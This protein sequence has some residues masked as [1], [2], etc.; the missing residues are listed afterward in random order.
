[1]K[2]SLHLFNRH[3]KNLVTPLTKNDADNLEEKLRPSEKF[4]LASAKANPDMPFSWREFAHKYEHGTIRN[5]FSKLAHLR[6]LEL[7]CRSTDAYYILHTADLRRPRQAVTVTHTG[8]KYNVRRMKIDNYMEYLDSLGWEEIWKV[9]DVVLCFEVQGLYEQVTKEC[10][11]AANEQSK[12]IHF[13]SINWQT[14]RQLK[15]FLHRTGTVTCYLKCS[16]SP[17]E[18]TPEG[19]ADLSAVLGK[20]QTRLEDALYAASGITTGTVPCVSSWV[21]T[22]WHCGKD[23]KREISGKSFNITYKTW[24]GA[25]VRIYL[26]RHGRKFRPRKETIEQPRKV[27]PRAFSEKAVAE[28]DGAR[29]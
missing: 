25:L 29:G 11:L 6:L 17:V 3:Y 21:V 5:A 18:V 20:V 7:Q 2:F 1:M 15:V 8:G 16:V 14:N 28:G 27:L 23:G 4:I 9:H 22:Q 19:L 12:D 10:R 13:L 26:K 24:S